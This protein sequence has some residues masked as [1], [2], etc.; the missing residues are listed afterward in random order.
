MS[1][2][3][4]GIVGWSG[5]GKTRLME[6]LIRW[7]RCR[8]YSVSAV[9][10]SHHAIDLDSPGKDSSRLQAAGARETLFIG[11]AQWMIEGMM[12]EGTIASSKAIERLAPCD[13]VLVEGNKHA[14]WPKIEVYRPALGKD[15]LWPAV[16]GI[17]AVA[18]DVDLQCPLPLLDVN[19]PDSIAVFIRRIIEAPDRAS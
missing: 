11:P 10:H 19:Q 3:V 14:P 15:P 4:V 2:P 1:R 13:L 5:A 6:H 17:L 16:S 8:G 12:H 7:F 18:T 9:K